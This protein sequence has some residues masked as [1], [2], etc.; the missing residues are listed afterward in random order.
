MPKD[1]VWYIHRVGRCGRNNTSGTSFVIYNKNYDQQINRLSKKD[2]NW[3]FLLINKNSELINKN[4][5]LRI[6]SKP[7]FDSKTNA[8]I[9][10]IIRVN[11][12]KIKPGYKKKIKQQI[13][14]IK[15][16]KKHEYIESQVK[17]RLLSSNIKRTKKNRFK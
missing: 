11:S 7:R 6:K 14:K 17:Q 5:R 8:E 16:K 9:Q 4:L 13:N 10:K 15:Q 2:I 3:N 1:D 12:K